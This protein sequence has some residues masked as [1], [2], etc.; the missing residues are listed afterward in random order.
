MTASLELQKLEY[1]RRVATPFISKVGK[2]DPVPW[3]GQAGPTASAAFGNGHTIPVFV[4][5]LDT[6]KVSAG[7]LMNDRNLIHD[8]KTALGG[9]FQ[10][11]WKNS[12]GLCLVVDERPP[13]QV[14]LVETLA[15][16]GC[17][18]VVGPRGTGKTSLLQHVI[19]KARCRVIVCDPKLQVAGKW[20]GAEVVGPGGNYEAIADKLSEIRQR[21]EHGG[22]GER[23]LVI[24]D[25][26]WI[27]IKDK[28]VGESIATDAFRII[29]LGR[30]PQID[31]ILGTHSERVRGMG[32]DGEGDLRD[33]FDV[34]RLHSGFTATITFSGNDDTEHPAIHPGPFS[35]TLPARIFLTDDEIKLVQW[36]V[37]RNGGSF[38]LGKMNECV[39]YT[40][41]KAWD[42]R[43]L[44]EEWEAKGWLTAG[45]TRDAEGRLVGRRVT[46]EL[47]RLAGIKSPSV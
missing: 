45:D 4:F 47:M 5:K 7:K 41:L 6:R 31:I 33:A 17:S 35:S 21:M 36:A 34:V 37:Y 10:V 44:A 46:P 8:I 23:L 28:A 29:T 26:Y 19:S 22:Y 42:I 40:S 24:V 30:E 43:R 12:V 14:D 38:S 13:K 15:Q 25:E 18:L 3:I 11:Y 39:K 20:P 32:I 9:R 27:S 2:I 1:I 16:G